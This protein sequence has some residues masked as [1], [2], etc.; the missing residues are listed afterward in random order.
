MSMLAVLFMEALSPEM[1]IVL[2]MHSMPIALASPR[3][4]PMVTVVRIEVIVYVT[5][6]MF[7]PM[8]P[9]SRSN[10]D[11]AR[12]PFRSVVS[13]GR[14]CIRRIIKIPIRTNRRCSDRH[15][16]LRRGC[17][18]SGDK[19]QHSSNSRQDENLESLHTLSFP[20]NLLYIASSS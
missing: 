7:R 11:T 19:E 1:R 2:R 12:K 14:A 20:L 18:R 5:A 3:E 10:K 8:E 9:R 15:T 13:V 6:K 16:E 4:R 17:L